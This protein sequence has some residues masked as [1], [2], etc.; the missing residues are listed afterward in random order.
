VELLC[1]TLAFVGAGMALVVAVMLG[2]TQRAGHLAITRNFL[3]AQHILAQH[4]PPPDWE[5]APFLRR[6]A[7]RLRLTD[8][9]RP[10][11]RVLR[12]MDAL[13]AFFEHCRFFADERARDTL[14]GRLREERERWQ[15]ESSAE[16]APTDTPDAV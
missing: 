4:G 9:G 1:L 10:G 12:R 13:I 14:L 6:L 2:A 11:A 15:A 5:R 7:V 16:Q 8:P 3:A